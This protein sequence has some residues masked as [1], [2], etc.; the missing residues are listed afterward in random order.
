MPTILSHTAIPLALG[1]GLGTR[2][3]PPR[4]LIAG[5]V[6]SIIPDLDVLAFRLHIPYADNFGHRGASHSLL[7]ALILATISALFSRQLIT[8]PLTA[9]WFIAVSA[10]SHGILDTFTNGGLGVALMWPFSGERYF[11]PWRVIEVS[12]LSLQRIL[13]PRGIQVLQSELFWIWLPALALFILLFAIRKILVRHQRK[14]NRVKHFT[15]SVTDNR[16]S[17]HDDRHAHTST[18]MPMRRGSGPRR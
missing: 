8:K 1:L 10:A 12:P 16:R 6:A 4:L 3:I 5:I 11:T 7:F 15:L 17:H 18:A 14:I 13:S 9:F 2:V